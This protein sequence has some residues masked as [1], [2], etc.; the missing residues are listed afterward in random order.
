MSGHPVAA[1][2][3]LACASS[4]ACWG[5]ASLVGG[6]AGDLLDLAAT[7][8]PAAAA[9]LVAAL[10]G[11][12]AADGDPD[13]RRGD[14]ARPW[15]W[16]VVLLALAV[17]ALR[18]D[19]REAFDTGLD[20]PRI[21]GLA[22]VSVLPALV[23][24]LWWRLHRGRPATAS[25]RSPPVWWL[26]A[27][28]LF[29]AV[30][31]LGTLV[32]GGPDELGQGSAW[33]TSATNLLLVLVTTALFGGPLGEELGWRGF[34]LPRLQVAHTPLV[35]S[36]VI[37]LVWGL[38]HLPLHLRGDYDSMGGLATGFG[39]RLASQVA[40]AVVFTWLF[41]RSHR[42]LVAVVLLHASLNNTIG[43]W[44]PE[45]LGF[46]VGVGLLATAAVFLDR[47]YEPLPATTAAAAPSG[48]ASVGVAGRRS[49]AR[50]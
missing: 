48:G 43:F 38:W 16:V 8:G 26:V 29:P 49:G 25:W 41:N 7:F 24:M 30:G 2:A 11:R 21:I 12:A 18:D 9:L 31:V 39:L 37:G 23:L 32:V 28:L 35:A 46:Q 3:V 14:V 4:W 45:S 6:D 44:L 20:V 36:V 19:W 40:V 50:R 10:I 34:A 15:W 5:L 13:L 27:L 22:L 1:F 17:V 47:M 42:G 33:P